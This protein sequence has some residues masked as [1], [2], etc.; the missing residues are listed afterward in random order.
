MAGSRN[1]AENNVEFF[2]RI[3]AARKL[4][5]FYV[6]IVYALG[7]AFY[8]YASLMD[9]KKWLQTG[10]KP[11]GR[12]LR[13]CYEYC[14]E[15]N[16]QLRG[17]PWPPIDDTPV[18]EEA[19]ASE[20][21]DTIIDVENDESA[22]YNEEVIESSVTSSVTASNADGAEIELSRDE[23][24]ANEQATSQESE[25]PTT[26]DLDLSTITSE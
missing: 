18:T 16:A 12:R 15:I 11:I 25:V 9:A 21:Q 3:H 4:I 13:F 17:L 23:N 7:A 8:V 20:P 1:W 6:V 5:Q 2:L 10:G 26:M 14:L 19:V 22:A 24:E